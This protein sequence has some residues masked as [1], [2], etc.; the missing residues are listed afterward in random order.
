MSKSPAFLGKK[1]PSPGHEPVSHGYGELGDALTLG[2]Q[3]EILAELLEVS[4]GAS[5]SGTVR[6]AVPFFI[7]CSH[8]GLLFGMGAMAGVACICS[9]GGCL[10]LYGK[11]EHV[12]DDAYLRGR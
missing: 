4:K 6:K 9:T 5:P 8:G 11:A 2:G 7:A 10:P 1:M 3:L 12:T